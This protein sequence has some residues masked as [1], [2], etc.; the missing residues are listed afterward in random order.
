MAIRANSPVPCQ[1]GWAPVGCAAIPA[2]ETPQDIAAAQAGTCAVIHKNAWNTTWW[3]DPLFFGKYPEDGLKLF[4]AD[5]PQVRPG[6]ME[7]I[8]Q[9]LD[10]FAFNIYQSPTVH[11]SAEGKPEIVPEPTGHG[12]TAFHWPVTPRCLYWASK[13]FYE[14]Y[15]L[16]IVITENGMACCDWVALDGKVHDAPRIDFLHRYLRELK[17]AVEE[18]IPVKGYFVWSILDNFEWAEGYKQRFG[19]VHVDYQTQ[20]RTLKDSAYWYRDVIASNGERL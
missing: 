2:T 1:I 15:K 17:R 19:I 8:K 7:T 9:P 14:R 13:F 10:F 11:L 3:N 12:L 18:G 6:D 5:A 16:P 20:K 4:G